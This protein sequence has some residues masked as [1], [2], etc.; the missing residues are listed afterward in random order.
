MSLRHLQFPSALYEYL[1]HRVQPAQLQVFLMMHYPDIVPYVPGHAAVPA[2]Q[3]V[4]DAVR[5]LQQH[6]CIGDALFQRLAELRRRDE[7][8]RA[9]AVAVLGRD[10]F[11]RGGVSGSF[12][13][14]DTTPRRPVL[15]VLL[16]CPEDQAQ[17]D[18]SREADLITDVL[19]PVRD[20]LQVVFGW[21]VGAADLLDLITDHKPTWLH[22]GG[23]GG[24]DGTLLLVGAARS[25]H[26]VRYDALARFFGAVRTPPKCVVLNNCFS[27]A[28]TTPLTEYVD[29]VIGMR[30]EVSDEA[31]MAFS[32]K[33]YRELGRG[34]DLEEAFNLARSGLG[35]LEPPAHDLPQL[36]PRAGSD[37]RTLR[38]R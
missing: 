15:L 37:L 7:D 13:S 4:F 29:A 33:L 3:Y 32:R 11:P 17:L 9:V 6:G 23:H 25:T 18:L 14:D 28:A 22:F 10:P 27:G 20:D 26:R 38:I 35:T 21:S 30:K 1:L 5:A 34:L 16:A 36:S 24:R 2:A 12:A 8:V 19:Q 31:A